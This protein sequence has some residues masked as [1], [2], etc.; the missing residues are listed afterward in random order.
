M[1][2]SSIY[3]L[4]LFYFLNSVSYFKLTESNDFFFR[5]LDQF[6]YNF[7]IKKTFFFV[8]ILD[9]KNQLKKKNSL[10]TKDSLN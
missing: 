8:L 1:I 9:F 7:F 2:I 5:F 6:N 4:I 10:Q 3:G